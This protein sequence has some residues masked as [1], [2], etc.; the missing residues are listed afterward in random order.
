DLDLTFRRDGRGIVW[1]R[2]PCGIHITAAAA[3]RAMDE[4]DV[5]NSGH[6]CPVIVEMVGIAG[7]DRDA[8]QV[9]TG[10]CAASRM[11]LLG[12]SPMERVIANFA[13]AVSRHAV[14]MR[15]FATEAAAVEWLT[16]A[17]PD[18]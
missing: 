2:W 8:R 1:L 3:R 14:P 9:F 18:R 17:G 6:K 15:Y 10:D 7:L 13:I 12:G 11:A 16:R 4:L 5:F